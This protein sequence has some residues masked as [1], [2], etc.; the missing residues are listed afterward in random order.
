[1]GI[2]F[3]QAFGYRKRPREEDGERGYRSTCR[4]ATATWRLRPPTPARPFRGAARVG[5]RWALARLLVCRYILVERGHAFTVMDLRP[6]FRIIV[7]ELLLD[8]VYPGP[9][10]AVTHRPIK[11]CVICTNRAPIGRVGK[12]YER[13]GVTIT[14]ESIFLR[15]R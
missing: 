7:R 15:K 2:K 4:Y 14:A 12:A 13:L 6:V 1:M 8:H 3:S 5:A 11:P 10:V 9:H